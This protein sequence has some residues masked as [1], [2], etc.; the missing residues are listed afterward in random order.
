MSADEVLRIIIRD[1][2]ARASRILRNQRAQHHHASRTISAASLPSALFATTPS[3]PYSGGVSDRLSAFIIRS[4][5]LDDREG[6]KIDNEMNKEQ[7]EKL[8]KRASDLAGGLEG[9]VVWETVRMQVEFDGGFGNQ[10]EFLAKEK[11]ARVQNVATI[12]REIL[13]AKTK[14][15]A[16]YDALYGKIITY[17]LARS[18]IGSP[19]ELRAVRETTAAL[20]SVFPPSELGA[21]I[22]LGRQE[23]EAQLTGLMQLV[24]G[25]RLFNMKLGKGGETIEKLPDLCEREVKELSDMLKKMMTN[26]ESLVQLYT[27]AITYLSSHDLTPEQPSIENLKSA[28]VF[29]RQLLTYLDALQDTCQRSRAAVTALCA[30]FESSIA[31]L[32]STCR[33]KTAVPVD[34]VYPQFIAIAALWMAW[35]DELY[36]LAFRQGLLSQ[37][38]AH[39]QNAH[40]AIPKSITE[41][42]EPLKKDIEPEI[43]NDQAIIAKASEVM[44]AIPPLNRAVEVVHPGNSTQYWKLPVEYGGYCPVTLIQQNGL[45]VPGDKSICLLKYKSRLF[46]PSSKAAALTFA[47]NPDG[48]MEQVLEWGR[49]SP[50]LVGVLCLAGWFPTVDVLDNA[51]YFPKNNFFSRP[52]LC[53]DAASQV[54]THILD[55]HIDPKYQWN[56]WELRRQALMLVALKTKLTHSAQTDISHFKRDSETQHY[57]PKVQE[58]QTRR[59]SGTNAIKKI[60]YMAGLR[61]DGKQ[62]GRFK[63]L[64]LTVE[65]Q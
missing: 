19:T 20:E 32:K 11:Q 43:L 62:S 16:A 36:L 28:L 21:F 29:Q 41:V 54:D 64:D 2:S 23:R 26:S 44:A 61:H 13:E 50:D 53:S 7:V 59:E 27:A 8:V 30:R 22:A 45:L 46:A 18:Y 38:E 55:Q 1:V 5:V 6:L 4:I 24:M 33:A 3:N 17:L 47:R 56:E 52:P 31:E 48:I 15:V 42:L 51:K 35:L 65:K 58:T 25:I 14:S 37:L 39:A 10:A 63:I 34:Q 40:V 60:N 9:G 49:K 12:A 57:A